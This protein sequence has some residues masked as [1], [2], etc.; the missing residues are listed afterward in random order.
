MIPLKSI[1][2]PVFWVLFI[3]TIGLSSS[4]G[5]SDEQ[6][7]VFAAASLTDV[8]ND[9]KKRYELANES[10]VKFNFGG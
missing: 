9:V 1:T 7:V 4:C 5:S 3:I 2:A 8:L 10:N 6:V